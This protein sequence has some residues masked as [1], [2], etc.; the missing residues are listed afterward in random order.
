VQ[1][2]QAPQAMSMGDGNRYRREGLR[3]QDGFEVLR[4][5]QLAKVFLQ[6]TMQ[7]LRTI[8]SWVYGSRVIFY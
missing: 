1:L 6:V 8:Q 3:I 2:G 7:S 5:V 4:E